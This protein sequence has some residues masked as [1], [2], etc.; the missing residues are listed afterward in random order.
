MGMPSNVEDKASDIILGQFPK[1]VDAYVN[2]VQKRKPNGGL[3][4]KRASDAQF[5]AT[6]TGLHPMSKGA[7]DHKRRHALEEIA[8]KAAGVKTYMGRRILIRQPPSAHRVTAHR[9]RN[10]SGWLFR[11]DSKDDSSWGR[12][13]ASIVAHRDDPCKEPEHSK[14][15]Q[16]FQSQKGE[17]LLQYE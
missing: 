11:P 14:K 10:E 8:K 17:L 12:K 9:E 7:M 4:R 6:T 3:Y 1:G 2:K 15:L 5:V 16:I 13:R